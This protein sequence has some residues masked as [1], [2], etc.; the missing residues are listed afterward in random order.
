MGEQNIQANPSVPATPLPRNEHGADRERRSTT[1]GSASNPAGRRQ[2]DELA[3][4]AVYLASDASNYVNGQ[5][6]YCRR[7]AVRPLYRF[8]QETMEAKACVL[9]SEKDL[10]IEKTC[11]SARWA[12]IRYWSRSVPRHLR[13]G[14]TTTLIGG[15]GVVRSSSRS[16]SGMSLHRRGGAEGHQGQ[17]GDRIGAE[18]QPSPAGKCKFCQAGEQQHC[19]DTAVYGTPCASRTARR[20]PRAHRR[21]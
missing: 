8:L 5:I 7:P 12:T 11:P 21:R 18:S 4:T 2:A 6:I 9:H 20:V 14:P 13:F 10:R 15:F 3:G 16:S 19:L 1:P 17:A